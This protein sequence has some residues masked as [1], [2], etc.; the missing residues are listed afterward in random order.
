MKKYRASTSKNSKSAMI[1]FLLCLFFGIFGIHRFYVGKIGTGVLMLMTGGGFGIWALID[2]VFIINNKFEDNKGNSLFLTHNPSSLKKAMMVIVSVIV[3]LLVLASTLIAI[4]Y[5]ATS[6]LVDTVQKQLIAL[7]SDD[8]TK[9]YSYTSKDFQKMTTLEDFKN[10]LNQYPS[11][12]NNKKLSFTERR[13]ENDNTGTLKGT[14]TSKEGAKT[15]IEYLLIKE[16]G[17]WKILGITMSPTGAGIKINH[18]TSSS[19]QH[20]S[21]LNLYDDKSAKYSIKYPAN[22]EYE[23]SDKGTIIFSGKKGTPSF[24]S[25]VN[26]QTILSKKAGGKYSTIEELLASLKKQISENASNDKVVAQGQIELPQNSK[27]LHGK[28]LIFTYTYRNQNFKQ[29]QFVISRDDDQALYAWAYTSP[30]E[31]YNADLSTAKAMYES[32]IIK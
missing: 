29:M 22:W 9:A 2:L 27:R 11:L 12:K 28:Y 21:L 18:D 4:V 26:I 23:K 32:W 10:F 5:Y 1:T 14:L 15:P 31:Q 8:I 13:I 24:Y 25:T 20:S 6:G 17:S 3:W 30:I 19:S 7:R 16:G